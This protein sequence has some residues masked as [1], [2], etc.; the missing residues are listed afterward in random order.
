MAYVNKTD[1]VLSEAHKHKISAALTGLIRSDEVRHNQKKAQQKRHRESSP[2]DYYQWKG[3]EAG[4]TS[5]HKWILKKKGKPTLCSECGSNGVK[6][7]DGRN[8]IHWA[9]VDHKYSRQLSDY[10]AL[11]GKCHKA[12]DKKHHG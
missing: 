7:T 9:N 12:Y 2:E 4:Y 6:S 3:D 1:R 8:T 10:V 5:K 11:C